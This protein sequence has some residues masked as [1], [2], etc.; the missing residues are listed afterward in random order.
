MMAL[1]IG[2]VEP[3]FGV[4]IGNNTGILDAAKGEI[5]SNSCN[6]IVWNYSISERGGK[7]VYCQG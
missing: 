6:I 4:S 3:V 2:M 1:C 7:V 5:H